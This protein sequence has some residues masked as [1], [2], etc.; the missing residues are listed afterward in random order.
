MQYH[1]E[2]CSVSVEEFIRMLRVAAGGA[3]QLLIVSP[4]PIKNLETQFSRAFGA[5]VWKLLFRDRQVTIPHTS[6]TIYLE[7]SGT[8]K[9]FSLGNVY[10]P[11]AGMHTVDE[12]VKDS[13]S[14]NTF[15][16][17]QSVDD[18]SQYKKKYGHSVAV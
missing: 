13:R 18:L 7:A 8:T 2:D 14:V 11:Y 16:L 6:L 9:K 17:P 4:G 12:Y 3:T 1:S 10:L 15:F 5:A